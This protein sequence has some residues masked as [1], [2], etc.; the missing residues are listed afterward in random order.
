M[1]YSTTKRS[2]LDEKM[3]FSRSYG[4]HTHRAFINFSQ[5]WNHYH[6][7]AWDRQRSPRKNENPTGNSSPV[8]TLL[9]R[10]KRP[11]KGVKSCRD[12]K[13]MY[14]TVQVFGSFAVAPGCN[15][16]TP[17]TSIVGEKT[18]IPGKRRLKKWKSAIGQVDTDQAQ[19]RVSKICRDYERIADFG[20]FRRRSTTKTHVQSLPRSPFSKKVLSW[21]LSGRRNYEP[22]QHPSLI[23]NG[24]E[25]TATLYRWQRYVIVLR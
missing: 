23:F 14:C 24:F 2:F 6:N 10:G 3:H 11:E 20:W 8:L 4:N 1:P 15:G 9:S 18:E 12:F 22:Y 25:H 13:R 21:G 16:T 5:L 19:S 17:F 7:H